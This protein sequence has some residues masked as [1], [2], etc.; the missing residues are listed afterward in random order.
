[1]LNQEVALDVVTQDRYERLVAIVYVGDSNV[2]EWLVE[3]G[4]AWA[5]REY[6]EDP[7]YC[8]LE[9]E[10]RIA[11]RGLWRFEQAVAP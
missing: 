8:R 4:H 6:L 7:T 3:Q 9:H 5:Y 10:A 1:M 2:N 11:Q